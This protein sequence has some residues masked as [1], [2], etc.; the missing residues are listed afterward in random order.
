[1]IRERHRILD[2]EANSGLKEPAAEPADAAR[3]A[4]EGGG[5]AGDQQQI[6]KLKARQKREIEKMIHKFCQLE[7]LEEDMA[8]TARREAE[9]R[10]QDEE[11]RRQRAEE[12]HQRHLQR[13]KEIEAL[14]QQKLRDEEEQRRRQ[15]ERDK[16]ALELQRQLAEE[17]L[18][19][20][21]EAERLRL[22]RMEKNRQHLNRIE[23]ER[24]ARIH[25]VE[26]QQQEKEVRRLK[27]I[28]EEHEIRNKEAQEVA[29]KREKQVKIARDYE[30]AELENKRKAAD[31]RDKQWN[32]RLQVM[33]KEKADRAVDFAR[34]S[35]ERFKRNAELRTSLGRQQE[36]A[37]RA[38]AMSQEDLERRL[39]AITRLREERSSAARLSTS[40]TAVRM[41]QR[42]EKIQKQQA[43]RQQDIE[44][45]AKRNQEKVQRARDEKD[46]LA[47]LRSFQFKL[48]QEETQ[49]NQVHLERQNQRKQREVVKRM[50]S[51]IE[52]IR[53]WENEK[54]TIA[55]ERAFRIEQLQAQKA[56]LRDKITEFTV[57]SRIDQKTIQRLALQYGIDFKAIREQYERPK[58]SLDSKE[59]SKLPKVVKV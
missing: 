6:E 21:K 27:K 45:I 54:M 29:E 4:A 13:L 1:V 51:E 26:M 7:R 31:E 38:R 48:K 9:R 47:K 52:R 49:R 32:E 58:T 3:P 40:D 22:E 19:Q 10:G 55:R 44:E 33:E 53:K 14:E 36:E 59:Q 46:N 50:E 35:E 17:K 15:F 39:S 42:A 41:Q 37:K 28:E 30:R 20:M 8:D 16:K 5:L 34:R 18:A 43:K 25:Q 57:N 23:D 2:A 56:D 12:V 11:L 24:K